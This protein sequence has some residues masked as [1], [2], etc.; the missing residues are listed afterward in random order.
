MKSEQNKPERRID[1][2]DLLNPTLEALRKLG[3]SGT[4]KEIHDEAVEI[5]GL[6]DEQVQKPLL[7]WK[8]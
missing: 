8:K 3:G 2:K 4:N 7:R 6:T 5:L 1:S